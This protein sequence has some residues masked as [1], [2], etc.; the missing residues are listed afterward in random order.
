VAFTYREAKGAASSLEQEGISS[1]GLAVAI[2]ADG[3]DPVV[4]RRAIS[5]TVERFGGLEVLVNNAGISHVAP[6]G[7]LSLAEFD[8]GRIGEMASSS[9]WT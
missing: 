1:G 2:Q 8:W 9:G 7:E 5:E 3:E 6:I 4:L